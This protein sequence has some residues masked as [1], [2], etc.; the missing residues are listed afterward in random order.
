MRN[1]EY[2]DMMATRNAELGFQGLADML[3][4][5]RLPSFTAWRWC[6]LDSILAELGKVLTSLRKGFKAVW[7]K[8]VRLQKDVI[9]MAEALGSDLWC[10]Q[11]TV[12]AWVCAWISPL[13]VW[14][15]GCDCHETGDAD[16]VSCDMRGRRLATA[17]SEV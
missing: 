9:L 15:G 10:L 13:L 5:L 4:R 12:V 16:F 8:K 11:F 2:L 14:C 3:R 6:K 7:L 1:R 17:W